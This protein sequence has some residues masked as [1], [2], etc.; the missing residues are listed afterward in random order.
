M[1]ERWDTLIRGGLVIDGTGGEPVLEDVA[2]A[3]GRIAARGRGLDPAKA[4]HLL[5]VDGAWVTPGLIDLHTP[6]S[7]NACATAPRRC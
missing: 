5:D 1:T 3:K 7:R 4:E 2:I 6:S